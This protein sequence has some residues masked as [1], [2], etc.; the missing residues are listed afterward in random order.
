VNV[1]SETTELLSINP[2]YPPILGDFFKAGGHPQTPSRKYPAPLFHQSHKL[3]TMKQGM[4]KQ[5]QHDKVEEISY[6]ELVA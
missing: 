4:L 3:N 1:I 2:L 5:V 6:I